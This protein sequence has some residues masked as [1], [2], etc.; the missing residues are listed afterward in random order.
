[1]LVRFIFDVLK[2]KCFAY[3]LVIADKTQFFLLERAWALLREWKLR[4]VNW[5]VFSNVSFNISIVL[6][7]FVERLPD[8]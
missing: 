6:E 1:M 3:E 7:L 2:S 4:L 5:I 8:Y